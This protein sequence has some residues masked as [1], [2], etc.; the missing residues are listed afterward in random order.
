MNILDRLAKAVVEE[1]SRPSRLDYHTRVVNA[2]EAELDG[3]TCAHCGEPACGFCEA[4]PC[5]HHVC[6][7]CSD[8]HRHSGTPDGVNHGGLVAATTEAP[9]GEAEH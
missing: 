7:Q 5:G 9:D 1:L 6:R 3:N 4:C 8:V 2:L